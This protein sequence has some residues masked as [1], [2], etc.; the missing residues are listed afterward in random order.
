MN[1]RKILATTL[2]FALC[3]AVFSSCG[4]SDS[5]GASEGGEAVE[6]TESSSATSLPDPDEVMTKINTGA[7]LSDADYQLMLLYLEEVV[8]EGEASDHSYE[9]G[10]ETAGRYPYFMSFA[11]EL[12]SA[13]EAFRQ[14]EDYK[15]IMRRFRILLSY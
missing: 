7:Q 10:Q 14:S 3:G 8:E 5:S 2:S 13:P 1:K 12:N 9:S 11:N 15:N 6:I 4:S